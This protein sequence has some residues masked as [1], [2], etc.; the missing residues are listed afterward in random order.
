MITAKNKKAEKMKEKAGPIRILQVMSDMN[1]GGAETMIMNY[2]RNIERNRVQFDFV[3]HTEEHCAYENEIAELG[4]KLFRMPQY[5]FLN[6]FAYL[7]AWN[8]LLKSHPEYCVL[9]GHYF[10]FSAL[11]FYIARKYKI[12]CISHSHTESGKELRGFLKRLLVFP[13]RYLSNYCFACSTAAGKY[14]FGSKII[15][16]QKFIVMNNAIDAKLF[17]FNV[18]K[19]DR[20]RL[21][22]GIGD[23]L[24]I[25][26]VGRFINVKNHE[27]LIEI[28]SEIYQ[29]HPD[30]VLLIIGDGSLRNRIE[31]KVTD[32]GLSKNV[33]FT[34]VRADIP[35]LLQAMDVFLFPSLFEGLPLTLIEAQASG[36]PCFVSDTVTKEVKITESVEFLSLSQPASEWAK[37][38][39]ELAMQHERKDTSE[40][41]I[42]AGYDIRENAKWL[43]EFYLANHHEATE[44][45]A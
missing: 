8:D 28:F 14:L 9:H 1:R 16:G 10:T 20:G 13:L 18:Y 26:H 43:Q 2:Y 34:G 42:K 3:V 39:L 23:K 7:K 31:K 33:I 44:G 40:Q 21:A 45:K 32:L 15:Y 5:R 22:E 4:G 36:L 30:A 11:Y 27:F 35:D 19:R 12:I 37:K 25:G 24:V 29:M 38:A 6:H 41:I 17:A